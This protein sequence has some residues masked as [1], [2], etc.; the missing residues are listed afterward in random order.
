VFDDD[1]G[2][3][4]TMRASPHVRASL[5]GASGVLLHVER[6]RLYSLDRIGTEIWRLFSAGLTPHAIADSIARAHGAPV[7]L[8]YGDVLKFFIRLEQQGLI[9]RGA[10]EVQPDAQPGARSEVVRAGA[11][12]SRPSQ[13]R[14]AVMPSPRVLVGRCVWRLMRVDV[15]LQA[16]GFGHVYETVARHRTRAVVWPDG[17]VTAVCHAVDRACTLYPR[18]ALCLQRSAAAVCVLRD[19]GV[20]ASLVIGARKHSFR[21]HAWVEVDDDVVNDKRGVKDFY[22]ELDRF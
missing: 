1:E 8:V 22:D 16:R 15:M 19:H 4:M 3:S 2:A 5:T 9:V 12:Q 14:H 17:I 20:A 6:D 11:S 13:R 18:R 7:P 21:A 10:P